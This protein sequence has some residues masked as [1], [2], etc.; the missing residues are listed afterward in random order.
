MV[1]P[2]PETA[3]PGQESVWTYPRP[4]RV[5][6]SLEYVRIALAG[7]IVAESTV[8]IRVLETS[9]PPS[10]YLPRAC[11]AEGALVAVDGHT[12]CEW[13][14]RAHYADLVAGSARA[15][16]VAWTYPSPAEGFTTLVDHS[17]VMPGG[18]VSCWVDDEPVQPQSGGFYGGW[19]THRVV[20]PFKGGPGTW[21][22]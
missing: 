14:G 8:S 21:G 1:K 9:H 10:Y 3:G 7:E 4:P 16:R 20:G 13:K 12:V 6:P 22:W 15:E 11:F 2:R 17:A 18:L 5:E 19:I